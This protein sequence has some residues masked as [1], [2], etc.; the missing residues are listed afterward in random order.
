MRLLEERATMVRSHGQVTLITGGVRSG[1]S[2]FAERLAADWLTQFSVLGSQ[3][4]VVYVAT[5]RSW[6][7]E[8]AERIAQHRA[9]RPSSWQTVEAPLALVEAVAQQPATSLVLVESIDAWVSNRLIDADPVVGE[10]LDRRAAAALE[11]T[12]IAEARHLVRGHRE[13]PIEAPL[14]L[15]TL[16]AGM[17]VVPPYPLGRAFRD[18]LGRVN[19]T[20][21]AEA[22]HVYLLIAGIPVDV[23][24][25]SA[26][27]SRR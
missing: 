25:L 13:R 15:V 4:S 11:A 24:R 12:L 21:A 20:L 1:K 6:D 10:Q 7:D 17:G 5:S 8:M 9:R 22:D 26:E 3:C 23:K 27:L 2:A 14:V 18:L 16:E 19:A